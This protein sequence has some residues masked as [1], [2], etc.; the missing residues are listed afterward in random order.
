MPTNTTTNKFLLI[1]ALSTVGNEAI[2]YSTLGFGKCPILGVNKLLN[3]RAA[4]ITIGTNCKNSNTFNGRFIFFSK[5]KGK[6]LELTVAILHAN[7]TAT[8]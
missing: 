3:Q 8:K 5:T 1:I 6:T 7:T 4:I 2:I